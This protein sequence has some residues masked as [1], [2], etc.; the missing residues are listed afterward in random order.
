METPV[1]GPCESWVTADEVAACCSEDVGSDTTV[2]DWAAVA[3][4]QI[5]Y[6]LS[7]EQFTGAC[8]PTTERPFA[9]MGA[10]GCWRSI[11][12]P[13][14]AGA[15]QLQLSWGWWGPVGWGWGY[16]GC[17]EVGTCGALSR[18]KL[19]G[20]PVTE[21][22]EVVIDGEVIDPAGYRLDKY[23]WLTRLADPVT[24]ASRFWPGCQRLDLDLGEP[25][26]WGVTFNFGVAPP[27][28]GVRAAAELACQVY[29][30]CSGQECQLPAG[31]VQIDRQGLSIKRNPA[32]SWKQVGGAWQTGL[33]LVDM[34]LNTYNPAGLERPSTVWSPDLQSYS[35]RMGSE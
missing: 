12:D 23:M 13:L 28:I 1:L 6:E 19:A 24:G 7:G 14:S 16:E 3:A 18:A 10:C 9:N 20:Y 17:E 29:K 15:P 22:T 35:Q 21:V 25:G 4:S 5:L 26:T 27:L 33:P 34:F 2:L 31:T 30:A 32:L 11:L 8:G